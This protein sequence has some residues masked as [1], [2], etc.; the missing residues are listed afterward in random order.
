MTDSIV[1]ID[2]L[3]FRYLSMNENLFQNINLEIPTGELILI[4]GNN[5]VGK[6]TLAHCIGGI[7]PYLVQGYFE[8]RV[9]LNAETI[10]SSDFHKFFEKCGYILQN[11]DNQFVGIT[12]RDE[13][14]FDLLNLGVD[15]NEA[16][17]RINELCRVFNIGKLLEYPIHELSMGQ[18]QRVALASTLA[19]DPAILILDQPFSNLD[20]IGKRELEKIS[21][22][23][24]ARGKTVI[25]ITSDPRD[26]KPFI[27]RI[28]LLEKKD[29][30]SEISCITDYENLLERNQISKYVIHRDSQKERAVG[31]ILMHI[32]DLKFRYKHKKDWTLDGINMTIH[33]GEVIGITGLNGSGKSTMLLAMAGLIK[34]Q[35][36]SCLI[37]GY[38]VD[39]MCFHDLAQIVGIV[40]QNPDYQIFANSIEEEIKF[41]LENMLLPKTEVEIRLNKAVKILP[42]MTVTRDPHMLSFGQKKMLALAGSFAMDPQVYLIDEPEIGLDI[43]FRN[44]FENEIARLT[45]K[46]KTIV[47]ASHDLDLLKRLTDRIVLL[48]RGKIVAQGSTSAMEST[49]Q[50]YYKNIH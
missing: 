24:K 17:N 6:T 18:K 23:L 19:R 39:E 16:E 28:F 10:T 13:L 25:F 44:L 20:P 36:G 34:P 4:F 43:P 40:F 26:I 42:T 15:H 35:E 12:V 45:T 46:G 8:G 48:E 49:V 33:E 7:I 50:K 22:K 47:I 11:P 5:G 3:S 2:N 29:D 30:F 31:K 32:D 27:S 9:I 38:S 41:G 37:G 21:I 1:K 14:F